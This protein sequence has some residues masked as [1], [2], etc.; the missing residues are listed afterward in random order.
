M[1]INYNSIGKIPPV[2]EGKLREDHVRPTGRY[3]DGTL[4]LKL[5][6]MAANMPKKRDLNCKGR[7]LQSLILDKR[8]KGEIES[9]SGMGFAVSTE[10][11]SDILVWNG[12]DLWLKIYSNNVYKGNRE[13]TREKSPITDISEIEIY[14]FEKKAWNQY[15]NS[16]RTIKDK[17]AYLSEIFKK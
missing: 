11:I 13:I 15:L 3:V 16:S 2:H 6:H 17:K 10:N 1:K 5:Y 9:Y 7:E 14:F 12:K 8:H 4:V